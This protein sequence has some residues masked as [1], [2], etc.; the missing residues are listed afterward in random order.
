[1]NELLSTL[2]TGQDTVKTRVKELAEALVALSNKAQVH[3]PAA[4]ARQRPA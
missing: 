1:M 4:L 3:L 2:K